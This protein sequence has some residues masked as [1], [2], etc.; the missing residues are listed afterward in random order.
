[1]PMKKM[2]A[3]DY[4]R[5]AMSIV[6][7]L[8]VG[9]I[10]SIAT[11]KSVG[12]WYMTLEKPSFNPPGAVFGPVWTVLYVMMGVSLFLVWQMGLGAPNVKTGIAVFAVQ[13]ALNL[14]WSFAFFGARSPLAGAV[15]IAALWCAILANVL[16]FARVSR[17]AAWLLIP[18]LAWVSFASVLNFSLYMLNR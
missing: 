11:S 14:V 16:V 9:F 18:Y 5:L 10:G 17:P 4:A 15:V 3:S 2:V 12:T 8:L 1:M 6:V 7:P 13:L